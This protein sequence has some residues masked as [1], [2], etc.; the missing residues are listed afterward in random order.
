MKETN[1]LTGNDTKFLGISSVTTLFLTTLWLILTV[2]DKIVNGPITSQDEALDY[3]EDL[4][5]LYYLNYI[6]VTLVTISATILLA[7]LY[8]FC[9]ATT[10]DWA[11]KIALIFTPVYTI[12]ALFAY[13]SQITVV[14]LLVDL[15]QNPS[16]EDTSEVLLLLTIQGWSESFV[17]FIN[18][19]AYAILGIPS[20]I[21]GY[22]LF[23]RDHRY[24]RYAGILLVLNAIACITGLIGILIG[25]AILGWGSAIG[26]VLFLF[27]LVFLSIAFFNMH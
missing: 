15:G 3:V 1:Q 18:N 8:V 13:L 2:T 26:G 21:Y 24:L 4:D 16:Y 17:W 9:R 12:L 19:L 5:L 27:S 23:N 25:I 7:G 22:D 10:P 11:L 20:I 14:P 6:N